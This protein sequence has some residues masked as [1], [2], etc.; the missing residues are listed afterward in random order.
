MT[1]AKITELKP[2]QSLRHEIAEKL[3][4][5]ADATEATPNEPIGF[6]VIVF[7]G[8]PWECE[9]GSIA[10][11]HSPYPNGVFLEG[12]KIGLQQQLLHQSIWE[13]G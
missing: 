5:V 3:R 2:R 7:T 11:W 4:H 8:A 13:Q 12:V 10:N 9:N 6:A 1:A